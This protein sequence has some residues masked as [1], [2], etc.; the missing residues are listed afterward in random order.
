[1]SKL[2][3]APGDL[4]FI[5]RSWN[6]LLIGRIVLVKHQRVDGDWH[7]VLMGQ[8]MLVPSED[9]SSYVI[10]TNLIASDSDLDPMRGGGEVLKE[11]L[12]EV[13]HA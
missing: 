2:R 7:V 5:K 6:E 1:M 13:D 3:C 12:T 4:A 11:M 10:T 8:P 9:R